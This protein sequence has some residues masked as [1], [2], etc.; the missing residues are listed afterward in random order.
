MS[1]LYNRSDGLW[2]LLIRRRLTGLAWRQLVEWTRRRPWRFRRRPAT[3]SEPVP[4]A[5][6]CVATAGV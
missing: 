2:H 5:A 3:R 4:H 6:A 1:Y